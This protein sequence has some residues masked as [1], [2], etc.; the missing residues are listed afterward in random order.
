MR[1]I[2]HYI[3]CLFIV[4]LKDDLG[5]RAIESNYEIYIN[6]LT[7]G[8]ILEIRVVR[9]FERLLFSIHVLDNV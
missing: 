4:T 7:L 1:T 3:T 6:S 8:Q 5:Y 9:N 2:F